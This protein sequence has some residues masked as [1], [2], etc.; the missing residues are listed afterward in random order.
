MSKNYREI[1]DALLASKPEGAEHAVDDCPWCKSK[2]TASE[3][4]KVSAIYTQ[5]QADSLVKSAVDAAVAEA[6]KE[7]DAEL[8]QLNE[9]VEELNKALAERDETINGFEAEIA[10]REEAERLAELRD[11]RVEQVKAVASFSEEQ[12]DA[13]KDR[14]A[15]MDE[16]EFDSL[17]ADYKE[18]AS[19]SPKNEK[20][21][22]KTSF[23]GT[24]QTAGDNTENEFTALKALFSSDAVRGV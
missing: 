20:K 10:A 18:I 8:L 12:I 17:L 6:K 14:W 3:E 24:R 4:E 19:A 15:K 5:E 22:K 7:A 21:E 1:H 2:Q 23:D 13:R 11:A 9:Q 16:D